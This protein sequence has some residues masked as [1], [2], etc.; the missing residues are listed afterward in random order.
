[1]GGAIGVAAGQAAGY[2]GGRVD[3]VITRLGDL[4]LAFSLSLL[5]PAWSRSSG[6]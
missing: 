4:N 5:A 1:V 2:Y 6:P 3:K